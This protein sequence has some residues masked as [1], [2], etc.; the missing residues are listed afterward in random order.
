MLIQPLLLSLL[1]D[2]SACDALVVAVVPLGD[3]GCDRDTGVGTVGAAFRRAMLLPRERVVAA[4][5]QELECALSAGP[6]RDVA[7][8]CV[9]DTVTWSWP[10]A[11][12][13]R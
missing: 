7:V 12:H 4:N 5:V 8:M 10:K 9:S 11:L 1:L 6:R 13:M 2:L 3:V